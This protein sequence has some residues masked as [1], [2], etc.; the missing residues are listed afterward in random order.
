MKKQINLYQPSCY[1][2]REKATFKQFLA[3]LASCLFSLLVLCLI[4]NKQFVNLQETTQQHQ[5]LRLKKQNELNMLVTKLQNHQIPESK[6]QQQLAL[7][8]EIKA[9]QRLLASLAG[10]ELDVTVS[11][12]EL[13]RGFSLAN[14]SAVSIHDF[15]II[16]GRLNISGQAKQS[17]SVPLWLTKLQTIKELSGITF[18]KL[19]IADAGDT[20]GFFFQL[21]NNLKKETLKGKHND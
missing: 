9:K 3:L 21:S 20:K 14:T 6:L 18:E 16:D 7:Q 11:F 10:M 4:L 13:M 12:S 19:K 5:N 2:K 8:D 15:S 1:P 17:D